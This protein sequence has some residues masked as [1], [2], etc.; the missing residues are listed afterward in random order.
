[1]ESLHEQLTV[2]RLAELAGVSVDSVRYY[3]KQGLLKPVR[4]PDNGYRLY[5]HRDLVRLKFIRRAK[6]LGFTISEIMIILGDAEKGRSPCP[7]VRSIIEN[8]IRE[9]KQQLEESLALQHRME[10]A[11]RIWRELPDGIP[12]GDSICHLIEGVTREQKT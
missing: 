6:T 9:N 10:E 12:V 11:L 7:R 1:M 2:K 5:G 3:T 4:D 8:N